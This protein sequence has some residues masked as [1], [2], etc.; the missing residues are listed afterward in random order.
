MAEIKTFRGYTYNREKIKDISKVIA[1]PWDVVDAEAEKRLRSL[2]PWNIINLISS[3]AD[4]AQVKE[5]FERW[6]EQGVF[7]REKEECFYYGRHRFSW[8]GKSFLRKGVFA[9]LR[10]EDLGAGSV[11]PH[12]KVFEKYHTNR[13]R[14]MEKCRANFSP[15]FMLYRDDSRTIENLMESFAP[16]TEGIMGEGD[17]F[18]FGRIKNENDI[19]TIKELLSRGK[20][21]IADGHHRYQAALRYYKDNPVPENSFVLVFLVNIESPELL[22][23]PTHRYVTADV[24]FAGNKNLFEQYFDVE[25]IS[26]PDA[27]FEKMQKEERAGVFGVYEKDKFY[28]IRLRD[29]SNVRKYVEGD[30]SDMWLSLDT[31]ILHSFIFEGILKPGADG[32][33]YHQ[34][35]EYLSREYEKRKAGVIFFLRPVGKKQFA[36]ICLNGELMPQKTTYFYPKVPSGFIINRF[37]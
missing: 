9:L 13:Y 20:L 32:L 17:S 30:F 1:P 11:I 5:L 6:I 19:S 24:S 34:S 33:F 22:V 14:L 7:V 37:E 23:M 25:D 8:Q 31:V 35:A 10:L 27:M 28:I 4:P 36:D 16:D 15:V 12:E 18:A 29:L 26:S 3:G 2:S 21:I